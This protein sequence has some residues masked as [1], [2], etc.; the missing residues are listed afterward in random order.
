L[1]YLIRQSVFILFSILICSLLYSSD[2][3][4]NT[5]I[6]NKLKNTVVIGSDVTLANTVISY[7]DLRIFIHGKKRRSRK[8]LSNLIHAL[9]KLGAKSDDIINLLS[10]LYRAGNLKGKLIVI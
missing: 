3:S 6:I 7:K 8:N 1:K 5:V 9:N 10:I 2:E 4:A